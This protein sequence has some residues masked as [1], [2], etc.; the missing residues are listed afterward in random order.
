M[1]TKWIDGMDAMLADI[2]K[3]IVDEKAFG[4]VELAKASGKKRWTMWQFAEQQVEAGK[5]ERVWKMGSI[6][7]IP[8][9]RIKK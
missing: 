1:K 8:A 4:V 5:W 6:R 2:P 3:K 7:L 9:Y